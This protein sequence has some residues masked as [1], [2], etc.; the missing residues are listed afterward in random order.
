M[1]HW[2]HKIDGTR[3]MVVYARPHTNRMAC[4]NGGN[5]YIDAGHDDGYYT[6]DEFTLVDDGM[7]GSGIFQCLRLCVRLVV[8]Y[9]CS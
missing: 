1:L 3:N 5:C 7:K 6:L 9:A 4:E 8:F 2:T